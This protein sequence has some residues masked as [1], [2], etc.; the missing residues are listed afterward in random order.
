[1]RMLDWKIPEAEDVIIGELAER[2]DWIVANIETTSGWPVNAQ[3]AIYRGEMIWIM[4]IMKDRYPALAM[5]RPSNKS[6]DECER[7]VLRFLSALAWVQGAGYLVGGVGGGS[8]PNPMG[9]MKDGGFSVMEEFDL[10]YLPEPESEKALLAMALMREGRGLNHP[11]YSFLAFYRV[12]EL[13]I[14]KDWKTQTGWINDQIARG[15]TYPAREAVDKLRQQQVQDVG[16]HLYASGR[17]AM[18]HAKNDPIIDPDNP[19]DARR[20]WGERPIM[21]ALAERAIEEKFGVETRL[22][23]YQKH[24][25][26][27]DGFKEIFG[28]ELVGHFTRGEDIA[29]EPA[30]NIPNIGVEI[31]GLPPYPPL[32]NLTIKSLDHNGHIVRM[33][34]AS[35][36]E[37]VHF[38]FRLDFAED[39]LNFDVFS[40]FGQQDDGSAESAEAIAECSRF[41]KEYFGNGQLRI[42]NAETGKLISRKDAFIP[43]NM[44][45]D[46]D[47]CDADIARWKRIAADR[48]DLAS[49][50]AA[51]ILQYAQGYEV[52]IN[53][54]KPLSAPVR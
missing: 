27:L 37:L 4:P 42:V 14:G 36:N 22:T 31:R 16:I 12:V 10:S 53:G 3:K 5:K 2:G 23:V 48:L 28:P 25:Y 9:R 6:R 1:M 7:L 43:V 13:A 30:V 34:F 17:C 40:D 24:R 44:Y 41:F 46:V 35:K 8:M 11:G 47:A 33:R 29:G 39:R 45:Q 38:R 51:T 15:L 54:K 18:A 32:A 21:L 50:F 49:R 19:A 20:L 26:E 52:A